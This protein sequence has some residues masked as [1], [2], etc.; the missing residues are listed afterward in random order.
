MRM[1]YGDDWRSRLHRSHG[2]RKNNKVSQMVQELVKDYEVGMDAISR[3]LGA[4][5]WEWDDGLSTVFFWQWT[6]EHRREIRDGLKVWFFQRSAPP[7][8]RGRQRWP[9]ENERQRAQLKEKISK[10]LKRQY[11]TPGFARSLTSFF[12]VPKGVGDISGLNSTI[13]APRFFLPNMVS[14]LQNADD[15]KFYG[16]INKGEMFLNYFLNA[17][18]RPWAGVDVSVLKTPINPGAEASQIIMQWN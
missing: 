14:M 3:A 11:I 10:V 1:E 17:K 4:S 12:A 7:S 6:K 16:D 15:Q 8:Y 9:A 13:W 2:G 18:L 5:F